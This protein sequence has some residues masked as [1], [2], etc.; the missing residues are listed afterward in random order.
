MHECSG[1]RQGN[2]SLLL[3]RTMEG[4]GGA[5][6]SGVPAQ[7]LR[8]PRVP[9]FSVPRRSQPRAA[10]TCLETLATSGLGDGE[11]RDARP[12]GARLGREEGK[13]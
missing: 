13:P 5:G 2:E 11:L 6:A 8:G 3:T 12:P 7:L 9:P 10:P 4:R 1:S